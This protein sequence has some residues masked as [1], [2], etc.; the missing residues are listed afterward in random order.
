M[1][2]GST[3]NDAPAAIYVNSVDLAGDAETAVDAEAERSRARFA[4]ARKGE[5]PFVRKG[6][7]IVAKDGTTGHVRFFDQGPLQNEWEAVVYIPKNDAMLLLVL[8]ARSK[9]DRDRYWEALEFIV[10]K[11]VAMNVGNSATQS[12]CSR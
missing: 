2:E 5:G 4:P 11:M 1:P 9:E 8:S 7:P 12:K 10:R 6:P 3:F